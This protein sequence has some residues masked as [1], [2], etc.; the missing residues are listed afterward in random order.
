MLDG[1]KIISMISPFYVACDQ[2]RHVG[3]GRNAAPSGSTTPRACPTLALP[4]HRLRPLGR[5]FESPS[6]TQQKSSANKASPSVR[7]RSSSVHP[8]IQAETATWSRAGQ[9]DWWVKERR[10][11][12]GRVRGADGRQRWIRAVDLRPASGS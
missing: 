4:A 11:W 12:W 5:R 6:L 1:K 2:C 7:S 8:P 10:E 3:W 9:L